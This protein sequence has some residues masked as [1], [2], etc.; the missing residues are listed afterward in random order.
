MHRFRSAHSRPTP[1]CPAAH[2]RDAGGGALVAFAVSRRLGRPAWPAR[3][4]STNLRALDGRPPRSAGTGARFSDEEIASTLTGRRS[5]DVLPVEGRLA[6]CL[7]S[8]LIHVR[9]A[10]FTSDRPSHVR[11]GHGRWRTAVNAGQH[12]WKACWVQALAS[13]NLASSATLTWKNSAGRRLRMTDGPPGGLKCGP[14]SG[15]DSEPRKYR[16]Q[17][18]PRC[19]TWSWMPW[20]GLNGRTHA[21][22]ACAQPFRAGRDRPRPGRRLLLRGRI[23]ANLRT[24]SHSVIEK[25]WENARRAPELPA[26]DNR[27]PAQRARS[28]VGDVI[29]VFLGW[30]YV[31]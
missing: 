24:A 23:P 21:A 9:A 7:S 25:L 2:D 12:C 26:D 4:T 1:P 18:Q 27:V 3:L 15:L 17:T 20:T 16:G 19:S 11:A 30:T 8:C 6:S 31:G 22:E 28:Q 29:N 10:P 14:L 5:S 13:S